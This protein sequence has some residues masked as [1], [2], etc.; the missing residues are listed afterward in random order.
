MY[1]SL[2]IVVPLYSVELSHP[3]LP[4]VVPSAYS[5]FAPAGNYAPLNVSPGRRCSGTACK[6]TGSTHLRPQSWT[7]CTIHAQPKR[8]RTWSWHPAPAPPPRNTD[9]QTQRHFACAS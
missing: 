3:I 1:V 9:V 6:R 8:A 7:H 4:A 2:R 5:R